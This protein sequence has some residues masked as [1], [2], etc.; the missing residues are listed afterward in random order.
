MIKRNTVFI[1]G[2]GASM[3]YGFPSGATL[4]QRICAEARNDSA[5]VRTLAVELGL[6][7]R[8]LH[9]FSDAFTRSLQPSIDAFLARR[10]DFSELG[11]AC[12]AYQLCSR[13]NPGK[14]FNAEETD[15]WYRELWHAMTLDLTG[16]AM[17]TSNNVRFVTF[18]YDRS[19]EYSLHEATK[20]TFGLDDALAR[21]YWEPIQICHVYGQLGAFRPGSGDGRAFTNTTSNLELQI[22]ASG[23]RIIPEARG[24]DTEFEMVRSWLDWAER[25]CFLGFGFDELNMKRLGLREVFESM[26]LQ[27]GKPMPWVVASTLG[28]TDSEVHRRLL[29]SLGHINAHNE[30]PR[31]NL[32]VL[33]ESGIL[34]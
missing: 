3:P 18:N 20:H 9:Q 23:I 33:R 31:T 17:L 7:S 15:H 19:L 16:P 10:Q 6:Q 5:M 11:K 28:L 27:A 29:P 34:G 25:I 14:I 12:I 24:D 21:Q 32:M 22:A 30:L 8:D 2:A 4:R 1:L 13:E 26:S